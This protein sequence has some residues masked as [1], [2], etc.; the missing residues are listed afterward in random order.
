MENEI[1]FCENSEI[2]FQKILTLYKNA[3]WT[4]YTGKP[5]VLEKAVSNSLFTLTAHRG[6]EVIGFLR[7][8]GDGLTIVYIQDIIVLDKFRRQ[9]VGSELLKRTLEKFK[10]VRQILLL[11]DEQKDTISFY[12]SAGLRQ[13]KDLKLTSFI[14]INNDTKD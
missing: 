5:E 10:N 14:K 7:A 1:T 2:D 12:E 8:V 9:G 3:G 6:E 4:A 13:T 11:T